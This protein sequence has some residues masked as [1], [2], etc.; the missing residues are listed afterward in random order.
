MNTYAHIH[1]PMLISL[2]RSAHGLWM[3]TAIG[4]LLIL[5]LELVRWRIR[6]TNEK[7]PQIAHNKEINNE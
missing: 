6:K 7:R 1:T 4:V 5:I 2:Q 3:G